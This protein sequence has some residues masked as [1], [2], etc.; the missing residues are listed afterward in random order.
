MENC[1]PADV[2][3]R[4][5][6]KYEYAKIEYHSEISSLRFNYSW[7]ISFQ[8]DQNS[9]FCNESFKLTNTDTDLPL[10][11]IQDSDSHPF[12]DMKYHMIAGKNKV[13]Q[14]LTWKID[15]V[16]ESSNN[17]TITNIAKAG[18]KLC[19]YTANNYH[20]VVIDLVPSVSGR[21]DCQWYKENGFLYNVKT[22][23]C[24]AQT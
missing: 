1:T 18:R 9:Y 11:F 5:L 6:F 8:L 7:N 2:R 24:I 22:N 20:S 14:Q 3:V 19:M 16:D 13:D 21:E 17:F 23:Q 4:Q 15:K 12:S 10:F